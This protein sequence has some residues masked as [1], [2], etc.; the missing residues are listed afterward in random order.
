M[1]YTPRLAARV[2]QGRLC[3]R[4]GPLAALV[5]SRLEGKA[6]DVDIARHNPTRTGQANRYYWGVVIAILADHTGYT[7][8]EIHDVL[9][10]RFLPKTLALSNR[11]GELIGE[12]VIGGSTAA[13]DIAEF[14]DYVTRIKAW[15]LDDLGVF[16]PNPDEALT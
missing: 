7:P 15:A 6:V 8:D 12:D 9:K 13:L 4:D 3:W 1:P 10:R 11:N 14:G 5:L 2:E 16:I